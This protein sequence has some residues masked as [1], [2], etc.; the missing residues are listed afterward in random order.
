MNS[1]G[2][3]VSHHGDQAQMQVDR[4]KRLDAFQDMSLKFIKDVKFLHGGDMAKAVIE[5]LSET[6][7][8]QWSS[9]IIFDMIARND[10]VPAYV[11]VTLRVNAQNGAAPQKIPLIKGFRW[12]TGT[13]LK[14]AKD[15]IEALMSRVELWELELAK[16][17]RYPNYREAPYIQIEVRQDTYDE[18]AKE[19]TNAGGIIL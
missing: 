18:A 19:Y 6:L 4:E 1:Q 10:E 12:L 11:R 7:G 9:R 13:G 3:R 8:K 16:L 14:E 5:S 17:N 15:A 2:F